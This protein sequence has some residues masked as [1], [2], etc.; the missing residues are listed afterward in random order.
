M[1]QG[2]LKKGY[3][4][5]KSTG[6]VKP[7]LFNPQGYS[8]SRSTNIVEISSPGSSYP[9]FQYVSGGSRSLNLELY[10]RDT[11]KGTISSY[12]SFL[13]KFMPKK[14]RFNKPP[15]L[16]F[17]MGN[18]VRECVLTGLERSFTEFNTDLTP[19]EATVTLTLVQLTL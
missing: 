9:V 17:A 4:K 6:E 13:E 14:G 12:L 10:L 19:K 7:F 3:I 5:N 11:K 16:I 2:A 18:D 15:V 8:D 1:G